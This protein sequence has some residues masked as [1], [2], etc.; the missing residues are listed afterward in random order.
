M[1]LVSLVYAL[2]LLIAITAAWLVV[3]SVRERRR[4]RALR[5]RLDRQSR[6]PKLK[7]RSASERSQMRATEDPTTVLNSLKTRSRHPRNDD[8]RD[9]DGARRPARRHAKS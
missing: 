8:A 5:E 7:S 2:P 3:R 4:E 9:A 6:P 1:R